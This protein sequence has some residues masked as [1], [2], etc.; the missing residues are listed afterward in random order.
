MIQKILQATSLIV[1]A[2]LAGI[3][4]FT[5]DPVITKVALS[6]A[7]LEPAIYELLE[8]WAKSGRELKRG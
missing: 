4:I 6:W 2:V 7:V 8:I 5:S 3:G 1:N